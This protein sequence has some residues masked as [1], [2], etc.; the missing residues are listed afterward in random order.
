MNNKICENKQSDVSRILFQSL[1]NIIVPNKY[2][3]G[4]P[5]SGLLEQ[6]RLCSHPQYPL[7]NMLSLYLSTEE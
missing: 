3:K 1:E 5:K 4:D 2:R 7:C 6:L